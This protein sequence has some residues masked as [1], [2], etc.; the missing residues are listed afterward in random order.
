ML[1]LGL[2][3]PLRAKAVATGMVTTQLKRT[4]EYEIKKENAF[5]DSL[6]NFGTIF[7]IPN[8]LPLDNIIL[9]IL[10]ISILTNTN[11]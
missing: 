8:L 3:G 4:N 1:N 5:F 11:C 6:S 10:L 7:H 2:V 9:I